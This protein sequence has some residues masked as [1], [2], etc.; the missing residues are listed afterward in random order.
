MSTASLY[1]EKCKEC[2]KL[3]DKLDRIR[4]VSIKDYNLNYDDWEETDA[5]M[6]RLAEIENILEEKDEI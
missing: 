5:N 1:F 4:E 3:K 2:D 6:Y